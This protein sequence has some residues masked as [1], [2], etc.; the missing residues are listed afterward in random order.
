M[1]LEVLDYYASLLPP[2]GRPDDPAAS[3]GRQPV[4]RSRPV[5]ISSGTRRGASTRNPTGPVRVAATRMRPS[6]PRSGSPR[7]TRRLTRATGRCPP[8]SPP[9]PTNPVM[10]ESDQAAAL[11]AADVENGQPET[12]FEIAELESKGVVFDGDTH[13][14]GYVQ[15]DRDV[16]PIELSRE[17]SW[18]GLAYR[19]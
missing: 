19:R 4:S 18:A 16:E 6:G 9:T 3:V 14:F 7:A 5:W 11:A 10:T 2:D 8:P 12:P 15:P 13:T 1:V 17:P